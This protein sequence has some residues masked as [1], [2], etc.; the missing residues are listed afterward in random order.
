MLSIEEKLN[1]GTY[2]LY[3]I[4][5]GYIMLCNLLYNNVLRLTIRSLCICVKMNFV[6]EL[7]TGMS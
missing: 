3:G 1:L 2:I 6:Y 5:L 7:Q 4:E